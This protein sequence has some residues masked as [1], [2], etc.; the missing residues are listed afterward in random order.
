MLVHG[1]ALFLLLGCV[2][3]GSEMPKKELVFVRL[4]RI[5]S[6]RTVISWTLK[7]LTDHYVVYDAR[8]TPKGFGGDHFELTRKNNTK[9]RFKG[10][11]VDGLKTA[12][13]FVIVPPFSES[14]VDVNL[15]DLYYLPRHERFNIRCKIYLNFGYYQSNKAAM[16]AVDHIV[17]DPSGALPYI[18]EVDSGWIDLGGHGE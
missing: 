15:N 8:D 7:N 14:S 10:M 13:V 2:S 3:L 18:T 9:I 17:S 12:D 11:A 16:S 5:A 4:K 6:R 1:F